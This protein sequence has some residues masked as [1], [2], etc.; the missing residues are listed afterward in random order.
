[1]QGFLF[2]LKSPGGIDAKTVNELADY[3]EKKNAWATA[4]MS[5]RYSWWAETARKMVKSGELDTISSSSTPQLCAPI[6]F[7]LDFFRALGFVFRLSSWS[8]VR[9]SKH[10]LH[11]IMCLSSSIISSRLSVTTSRNL[12]PSMWGSISIIGSLQIPE[13][14]TGRS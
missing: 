3:A 4:P 12:A 2:L 14:S 5:F 8:A 10:S 9:A 1:M 11:L 13:L 6:Q 7:E